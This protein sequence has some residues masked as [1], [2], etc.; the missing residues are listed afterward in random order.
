MIKNNL[1]HFLAIVLAL[2]PISVG[3][4]TMADYT[5]NPVFTAT[6]IT[7]NVL[8]IIDSS[9]SMHCT[10][11]PDPPGG[12]D[13]S[14]S[15]IDDDYNPNTDYYG[16]F[17]VDAQYTYINSRFEENAGGAWNGNFLN[18]M[19]TKRADVAKKVLT[20][21]RY[22]SCG[23]DMCL[24]GENR[25]IYTGPDDSYCLSF[26]KRYK[27][28]QIVSGLLSPSCGCSGDCYCYYGVND[29]KIY[30]DD[31]SS[32]YSGPVGTYNIQILQDAEPT[33]LIQVIASNSR[34]GVEYYY[35]AFG[36]TASGKIDEP[37]KETGTNTTDVIDSLRTYEAGVDTPLCRSLYTAI[38]YYKQYNP[39]GSS[40][41]RSDAYTIGVPEEDPFYYA[42]LGDY[43]RCGKNF[44]I[45][46]SDGQPVSDGGVSEVSDSNG[47]GNELDELAL[48]A[49]R[50]TRD[51][52]TDHDL[53][54]NQNLTIYMVYAFGEGGSLM[55]ETAKNGGFF[56][57]DDDNN[58][59][60]DMIAGNGDEGNEFDEDDDGVPDNYF[61]AEEGYELEGQLFEAMTE[62]LK[63]AASG[64][65]VSVLSTSSEGEGSLFQ[66]FFKPSVYDDFR[67]IQWVG[68]LN[69]LWLD[70]Y[71]NLRE[72]SDVNNAL[73]YT[74]DKIIKFSVD[75][76]SGDTEVE[77]YYDSDG[78]G[79]ADSD[80]PYETVPLDHLSP[81]W[82]AGKK[83]ALRDASARV[84]KTW[85]DIDNDAV[86]DTGEFI[87]F[88]TTNAATLRPFLD[89]ATEAE[90]INIISFIRGES[91]T[92]YRD[93]NIT[94][95]GTEY[96]WKLGDIVYSTPTVV[97]KP[98]E[99]YNQYYSDYTYGQFFTNW[100]DRGTTVYVG[101][102]DGMLHAF[103]AG[104]FN[105]GDNP[106][107]TTKEEHGWYTTT[108]VPATSQALGDERW[109]YIPYNLLP[110]LKWLTD[111]DYTH[112]YYVDLKPKVT[113]VRIFSND[114]DHPNGWGTVLIGGMRLGGGEYTF[115]ADFDHNP[116]T[117]NQQRTFRS[118]YFV[119]DVTVPNNPVLL[120]EF[121]DDNMGFTTSYPAVARL[122]ATEGFAV[123]DDQWFFVVGSGPTDCDGSS[124]QNGYVFVYNLNTKQLVKKFGP[125]GENN[126]FMA[127]PITIDIIDKDHRKNSDYNVD[128]AYIGETYLQGGTY[129]G[130]M[131][132]INTRTGATGW[133]YQLNP[134]NW[135]M[136][137]LFSADTPIT[138]SAT[139]SIDEDENVW[140][141]FG[142]GKYYSDV[143]KTDT[144]TKYFYGI[145]DPCPYGGCTAADEVALADLYNST[146]IIVL[147]NK[148]VVG[149]TATTWDTFVDEVQTK[150]GWY[151]SL[152]T[153]GERVLNRPS[154]LGGLVMF[155][156][157]IP[158]PDICNYGGSGKFYALYY[159]TGT[160]YYKELLGT[161]AY[162]DEEKSLKFKDLG[163][164]V[165]SEVGL[166]VGKKSTC[167]GFIQQ[168]T[169]AVEQ[170][171]VAPA[172]SIRSGIIGW[173]QY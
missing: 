78:D 120:G 44:V 121:T 37:I 63:R 27:K 147:T 75:E 168:S 24:K 36:G 8:F 50:E 82:E 117:P 18:W 140:V 169:G 71:G 19:T 133:T 28:A 4:Q 138:S 153:S 1:V 124:N 67:E 13:S 103:K 107:T 79:I 99:N 152:V 161:E 48:W 30:F 144:A 22:S 7:P 102:N 154:V 156:S 76:E 139:A 72:D 39:A 130:K 128:V 110:H 38:G 45:M 158:D 77:R 35:P 40:Y 165:T 166:H 70:P 137:T 34:L 132:R 118:A 126:A 143:D 58:P 149:A 172:F 96:V 88:D 150:E 62:I 25:T 134:N 23:S 142:A 112:V 104:T 173:Q 81:I 51:L 74:E 56:D 136:T 47:N 89:V 109:A 94:I 106:A 59:D 95:S 101:A 46:I 160:A 163:Q 93:R 69:A 84:I 141:Y 29:G 145:K 52:R 119:L 116:G 31:D 151:L 33:G 11:Y 164:G 129:K 55:K 57:K 87:N 125:T 17:D 115:S 41:I 148:E 122:E 68:Y 98:M 108:E 86:M 61:E 54:G 65:A 9:S 100:K 162:G 155:P 91:V 6:D 49:H 123:E 157:F 146:N 60:G 15:T 2:L 26:R 97:G 131:Y 80:T 83:L 66:A 16:Y 32:T 21:G 85:V 14:D 53:D 3:A 105:E 167:T 43:I 159:E 10:A 114:A 12:D 111:P 127:Q 135:V 64:T 42:D 5:C 20:G 113:D 90:A 171:E 92:S 170:V 73:V